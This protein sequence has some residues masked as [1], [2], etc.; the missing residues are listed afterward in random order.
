MFLSSQGCHG[1]RFERYGMHTLMLGHS[2]SLPCLC[3]RQLADVRRRGYIDTA[4]FTIAMYLIQALMTGKLSSVPTTLPQ[5]LYEEAARYSSAPDASDS[6]PYLPPP[7]HPSRAPSSPS[8]FVGPPPPR[9][10][11]SRPSSSRGHSPSPSPSFDISAATRVQAN[12]IFSSLD[13][14]NKGRISGDAFGTYIQTTGLSTN[15]INRIR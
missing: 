4:D 7:T 14:R 10:P 3:C 11:S 9:H 6:Q 8:P 12:H 5:Q 13:P 1:T 2:R 15:A